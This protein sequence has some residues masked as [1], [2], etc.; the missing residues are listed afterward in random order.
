MGAVLN[1]CNPT[2][3]LFLLYLLASDNLQPQINLLFQTAVEAS[4]EIQREDTIQQ[5]AV[6][7]EMIAEVD[8]MQIER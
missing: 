5:N 8:N 4:L 6:V 3:T 1:G 2:P 7:A